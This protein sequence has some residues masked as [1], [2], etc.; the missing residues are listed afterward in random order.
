MA[1]RIN[2]ILRCYIAT[3]VFAVLVNATA[4]ATFAMTHGERWHLNRV[5]HER[6]LRLAV[7]TVR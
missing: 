7:R 6:I 5:L 3:N 1:V 2:Y 4:I